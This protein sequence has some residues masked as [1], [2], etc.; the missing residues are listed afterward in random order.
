M[1][2]GAG[3]GEQESDARLM[4]GF[5]WQYTAFCRAHRTTGSA[6]L[7]ALVLGVSACGANNPVPDVKAGPAPEAVVLHGTILAM[8]P[9]EPDL[10]TAGA[11][12]LSDLKRAASAN[13]PAAGAGVS[14]QD[15]KE[16]GPA[17]DF[18]VRETGG[19][20]I[21]VVQANTQHFRVGDQ[22]AIVRGDRTRLSRP[23][24]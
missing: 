3:H 2:S 16:Q 19:A 13:P 1:A 22:V 9:V 14:V 12:V 15:N 11:T 18:V 21:A 20:T 6:I 5:I 8:R 4:N 23:G 7:L 17:M 24:A 10:G